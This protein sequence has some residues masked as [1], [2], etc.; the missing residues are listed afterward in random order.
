MNRFFLCAF[1][2]LFI[3]RHF[4]FRSA[5]GDSNSCSSKPFC[6]PCRIDR[7]V[8]ATDYHNLVANIHG[9]AKVNISQKADC[10]DNA[11]SGFLP[12]DAEI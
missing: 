2:L 5:I 8:S 1:D 11:S 3:G 10:I 9:V 7:H 6:Y 4:S 12:G